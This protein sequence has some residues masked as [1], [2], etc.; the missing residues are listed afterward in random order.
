M[1]YFRSV[2]RVRRLDLAQICFF[3]QAADK[4]AQ[5][6]LFLDNTPTKLIVKSLFSMYI[7][8]IFGLFHI[9]KVC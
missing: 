8:I 5:R 4:Q 7:F 3:F 1:L 2:P 6:K 9:C